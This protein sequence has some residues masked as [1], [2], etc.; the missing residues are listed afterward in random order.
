MCCRPFPTIYIPDRE[1]NKV[2][3]ADYAFN[4]FAAG[5]LVLRPLEW[6]NQGRA[7]D[8]PAEDRGVTDSGEIRLAEQIEPAEALTETKPDEDIEDPEEKQDDPQQSKETEDDNAFGSMGS[9]S[10][11]IDN[12]SE[13]T[14]GFNFTNKP[15][16]SSSPPTGEAAGIHRLP[17]ESA[18][19]ESDE[20]PFSFKIREPASN[21]APPAT[22]PPNT[23]PQNQERSNHIL[24]TE[25]RPAA[26]AAVASTT[27][28][29][30]CGTVDWGDAFD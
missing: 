5:P 1:R 6:R 19:A 30:D 3:I 24:L 8:D 12:D 18:P 2:F 28:T 14:G 9:Q 10:M 21:I 22:G 16:H 27:E 7:A 29:L 25:V 11:D 17:E 26:A 23:M 13:N 20:G 4:E 15:A